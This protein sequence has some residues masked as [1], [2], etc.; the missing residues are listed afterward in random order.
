MA[1]DSPPQQ[2]PAIELEDGQQEKGVTIRELVTEPALDINLEVL[3]GHSN[4]GKKICSPKVQ[5][6]GMALF[7]ASGDVHHDR[8]QIVGESESNYLQSMEPEER[9]VVIQRLKKYDFCC[10]V[11]MQGLEVPAEFYAFFEQAQIP[12]I[13]S[14]D[15]GVITV[16]RLTRYLENRLA[17]RITIHGVLLEVFGLGVLILGP[18][19]IGKSE[20]ALELVLKGHRLIADDYVDITRHGIDRLSGEG[21]KVLK[22][23]MELRGLGIINIRDLFGISA[24]GT[25]QTLDFV[26]RLERWKSDGEYDRLGLEHS[27]IEFLD[28]PVPVMDMPV[29]PGRNVATLVEIAA[30]IHLL[31]QRG[32]K[33]N[34]IE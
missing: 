5:K 13:R 31:R 30:R 24:T 17:P 34:N 8:V 26:V 25:A 27:T 19:G 2:K 14:G 15:N 22:H 16:A 32:Y 11:V 9:T 6:L 1:N 29:A 33:T 4:L 3:S 23:H 21:G 20:C 12:L 18:S 10:V 7:G 28:V